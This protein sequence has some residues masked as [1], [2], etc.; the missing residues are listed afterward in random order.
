MLKGKFEVDVIDKVVNKLT[1][2][3]FETHKVSGA[4]FFMNEKAIAKNKFQSVSHAT[5]GDS[6]EGVDSLLMNGIAAEY[7]GQRLYLVL[8]CDNERFKKQFEAKLG[9]LGVT[10]KYIDI[11]D[12]DKKVAERDPLINKFVKTPVHFFAEL[13]G[14]L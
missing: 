6:A 4:S 13:N 9:E 10:V 11:K 14:G 1:K 5:G 2:K 7:N 12:F 8:R 3:G